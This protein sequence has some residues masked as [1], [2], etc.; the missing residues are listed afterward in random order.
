MNFLAILGSLES[1]TAVHVGTG[2]GGDVTD[3]LCRRD[4]AGN[5]I[6]PG[7]ALGGAF[8][9]L[10]TR[11]APVLFHVS[12]CKAL[13]GSN[14]NKVCGCLVCRLCGEINP[15]EGDDESSGGRASRLFVAHATAVLP[16][17]RTPR[18]RDGVGIDRSTRASASAGRVKFDLQSLPKGTTFALRLE[19]EDFS[20]PQEQ[21]LAAVLAEWQAGRGWFGG[22]TSRGMGAFRLC[23]LK[24][25]ER[26]CSTISAVV[27]FLKLDQPW[28]GAPVID[29]WLSTRVQSIQVAAWN[30]STA[31]SSHDGV[32]RNYVDFSFR[33]TTQGPF[34]TNDPVASVRGGFDHAPLLDIVGKQGAVILPGASLR[35]ALRS[36]AERIA[37]TLATIE[38]KDLAEF[39]GQCPACNPNESRP[40]KPLANCDSLLR[41]AGVSGRREVR[42]D[43]LCMA[44]R[45]F[46]STRMGSRL[47]V[48]DTVDDSAWSSKVLDFLAIDRFT[49]GGKES[50]K[51]DA[52]AAWKPSFPVRLHLENAEC[53]ELGWLT[54]LLRDLAEGFINIGFGAAKGFGKTTIDNLSIGYGFLK[55]DEGPA[56]EVPESPS[57]VFRVKTLNS[58]LDGFLALQQAWVDAFHKERQN[59]TGPDE[60]ATSDSYFGTEAETLYGKAGVA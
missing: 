10:A 48:E 45:L 8:R 26:R 57:G 51:F 39:L 13:Q 21:L 18:I 24:V 37:R 50:A 43:Q 22:R 28:V 60:R 55:D 1:R 30:G 2:R 40:N 11:L 3:A 14:D 56:I 17:D 36:H 54:L 34:L 25:V 42:P 49:G 35:G 29:D 15:G 23:D 33:L 20:E 19:L 12:P 58:G 47:I 27:S 6:L 31:N 4:A 44:C 32:A 7:T 9:S 41:N 53:W 59:R 46:G 38:S 5:F 16:S 52:V